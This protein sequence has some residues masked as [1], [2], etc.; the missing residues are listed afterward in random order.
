MSWRNLLL[1]SASGWPLVGALLLIV[2]TT[3]CNRCD[4]CINCP[5]DVTPPAVPRGLYT[6]TGDNLV[7]V[8]W[9]ANIE[10]DVEGYD[11]W[12]NSTFDGEYEHLG[13]VSADPATDDI[14]DFVDTGARNGS[15]YYYAVSAFDLAGN[16]S[17][18]SIEEVSDTPRPQGGPVTINVAREGALENAGFDLARGVPVLADDPSADFHYRFN[19]AGYGEIRTDAWE[20]QVLNVWGQDMGF[21]YSFEEISFAPED[22]W[23]ATGILEV[24]AYHTYVLLTV[25]RDY[26]YYSKIWVKSASPSGLTFEWAHQAVPGNIQLVAAMGK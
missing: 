5:G 15:T 4:D 2:Y 3:G 1:R 20:A 6:I 21:T 8:C 7:I 26:G 24:I 14:L 10:D 25:E 19:P 22:G 13:T 11:I 18:L 17:D 16:E 23:S 9:Y 12:W